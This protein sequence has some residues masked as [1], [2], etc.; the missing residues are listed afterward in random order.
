MYSAFGVQIGILFLVVN[1][2][3]K[4][5]LHLLSGVYECSFLN[6]T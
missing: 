3:L 5:I 2:F 1:K 6:I 4:G